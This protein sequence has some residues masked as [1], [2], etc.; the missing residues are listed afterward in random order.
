MSTPADEWSDRD[1]VP[2]PD[3]TFE[4]LVASLHER[5]NGGVLDGAMI[6]DLRLYIVARMLQGLTQ[7]EVENELIGWGLPSDYVIDLVCSTR[8][9]GNYGPVEV[10][11]ETFVNGMSAGVN[12]S[13]TYGGRVRG[14][15]RAESRVR[16]AQRM[17]G[18]DGESNPNLAFIPSYDPA[19]TPSHQRDPLWARFYHKLMFVIFAIGFVVVLYVMLA[20]SGVV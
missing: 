14:M 9:A 12:R 3:R 1:F 5:M 19:L 13:P 4:Q 17:L 7:P 20:C 16:Q 8:S 6:E 18:I 2:P 11:R 15:E 10:Q